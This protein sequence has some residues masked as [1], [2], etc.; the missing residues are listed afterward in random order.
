MKRMKAIVTLFAVVAMFLLPA[1]QMKAEAAD[2][3]TFAVK[4]LGSEWRYQANTSKFDEA[5]G[6]R[7]LYYMHQEMK[8]GDIVV[9]YSESDSSPD[10]NLGTAKLSNVTV[11]TTGPKHV[12]IYAGGVE[13]MYVLANTSVSINCDVTRGHVYDSGICSFNGNVKSITHYKDHRGSTANIGCTGI[14]EHFRMCSMDANYTYFQLYNFHE[15]KFEMVNGNITTPD[16]AF[17]WNDPNNGAAPATPAPAAPQAPAQ[18]P[19]QQP[20]AG[21]YDS[22][23]KTGDAN[24]MLVLFGAASAC[25]AGSYGLKRRNK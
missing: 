8:D 9:V 17:S 14:V 22:V 11:V 2:P 15:G 16:W 3:V 1:A 10:L 21:G 23:P 19:A 6:H 5:Y 4:C 7:E 12:I 18:Q 24:M 13:D 20:A 25:L